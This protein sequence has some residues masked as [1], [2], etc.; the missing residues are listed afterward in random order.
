MYESYDNQYIDI[1][2]KNKKNNQQQQSIQKSNIH[3]LYHGYISDISIVIS[4]I[5]IAYFIYHLQSS[6]INGS[7]Y[8]KI[9]S[10]F[11]NDTSSLTLFIIQTICL[12]LN[13]YVCFRHKMYKYGISLQFLLFAILI[14][15]SILELKKTEH[16]DMGISPLFIL[17]ITI[18]MLFHNIPESYRYRKCSVLIN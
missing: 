3:C 15:Y 9:N 17:P 16:K 8:K 12:L 11:P 13:A 1:E 2:S 7:I 5:V 6:K 10:S 4:F 18:A 14:L